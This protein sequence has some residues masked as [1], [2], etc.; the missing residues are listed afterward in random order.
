MMIWGAPVTFLCTV[1]G[2]KSLYML[3]SILLS[4]PP[5][6]GRH[7]LIRQ[8]PHHTARNFTE[9]KSQMAFFFYVGGVNAETYHFRA[10]QKTCQEVCAGR[11]ILLIRTWHHR[12]RRSRRWVQHH[13]NR[14]DS[15]IA[16]KALACVLKC[17]LCRRLHD[18]YVQ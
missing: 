9:I 5:Y 8:Q 3:F 10:P 7:D 13:D 1:T 4:S 11:N 2:Y 18:T 12:H 14:R 15:N 6:E 16:M 17:S